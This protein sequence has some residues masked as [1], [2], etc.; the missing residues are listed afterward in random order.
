MALTEN[1]KKLGPL[2]KKPKK[3]LTM[4]ERQ[5]IRFGKG[6]FDGQSNQPDRMFRK[7][8][9]KSAVSGQMKGAPINTTGAPKYTTVNKPKQAGDIKKGVKVYKSN[10]NAVPGDRAVKKKAPI[11]P[12][13]ISKNTPSSIN[14]MDKTK[15]KKTKVVTP[16]KK[17]KL[18]LQQKAQESMGFKV[19]GRFGY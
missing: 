2:T 10:G 17:K 4:K 11:T 13:L 1:E 19:G 8:R 14:R 9:K 18:T 6:I 5:P 16:A 15:S 7:Q 12:S 3:K